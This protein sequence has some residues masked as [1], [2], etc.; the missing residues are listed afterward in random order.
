[1]I[2][3]YRESGPVLSPVSTLDNLTLTGATLDPTFAS[4]TNEYTAQATNAQESVAIAA[5]A[6]G[7]PGA[8][9]SIMP[10]DQD[11]DTEG[12]QVYLTPGTN[13]RITVTV[14]AENR[15]TNVYTLMVYRIRNTQS[16]NGNLSALSL[17][18]VSLSPA[19]DPETTAYDARVSYNVTTVTVAATAADIGADT[20][21]VAV[22][23]GGA[24]GSVDTATDR[25][26]TL[27][28]LGTN[29]DITVTVTAE[30]EQRYGLHDHG[31]PREWASVE[32]RRDVGLP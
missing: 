6:D 23:T 2:T 24:G 7:A 18:G 4:G 14:T 21:D 8:T 31:L 22:G 20:P 29:T 1:M 25:V 16:D 17:G 11:T 5:V 13:T 9:F 12:H 32:R 19:F 28:A 26:V 15:S 30:D 3:V 27:G 10:A